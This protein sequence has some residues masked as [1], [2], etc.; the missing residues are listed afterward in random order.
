MQ[1]PKR[2]IFFFQ[3]SEKKTNF[4]NVVCFRVLIARIVFDL[5]AV[6]NFQ[7]IF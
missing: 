4:K 3:I 1:S 6:K 2:H 5:R 7:R